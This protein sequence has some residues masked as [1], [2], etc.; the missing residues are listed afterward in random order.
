MCSQCWMELDF[1]GMSL[2]EPCR[3]EVYQIE[4]WDMIGDDQE[5]IDFDE[6]VDEI[7]GLS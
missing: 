7:Y 6:R 4:F 2:C 3:R 5:L 1:D